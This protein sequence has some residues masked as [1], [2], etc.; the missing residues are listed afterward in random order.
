MEIKAFVPRQN[1]IDE[2]GHPREPVKAN[3]ITQGIN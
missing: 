1:D 2:P 3:I